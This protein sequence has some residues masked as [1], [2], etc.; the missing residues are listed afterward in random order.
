MYNGV[1]TTLIFALGAAAGSAATWFF[2]KTKYEKMVQEEREAIREYYRNKNN[3][4]EEDELE[5]E[6]E[7][8]MED[9]DEDEAYYGSILEEEGYDGGMNEREK[10]GLGAMKIGSDPEVIPPDEFG[11]IEEYDHEYL[12]YYN[13]GVLTDDKD[14]PIDDVDA[15]V[16]LESLDR[17]GEWEDDIVHVR[18]DRLKTYYEITQDERD[19]SD[20]MAADE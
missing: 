8:I 9:D 3:K 15:V 13:D 7:S 5:E 12:T 17:F 19:Y 10:G 1:K 2:L 4:S 14:I 11:D 20:I 6:I 16:G 18:N